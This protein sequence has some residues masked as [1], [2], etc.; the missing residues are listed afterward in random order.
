M[1]K[2]MGKADRIIRVLLAAVIAALYFSDKIT[3][4]TGI[5][6]MILAG[7][8]VITSFIGSCP[9]YI[10]FGISTGKEE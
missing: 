8:F 2:N 9:L 6:L 7:V 5:I 1:K 4:T 3:G 10:P